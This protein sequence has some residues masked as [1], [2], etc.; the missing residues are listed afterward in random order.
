MVYH[1]P[2]QYGVKSSTGDYLM[3]DSPKNPH[4]RR[5]RDRQP[6]HARNTRAMATTIQPPEIERKDPPPDNG[7]SS[8]GGVSNLGPTAGNLTTLDQFAPEP[9]RTGIWVG[10]AAITM[11]VRRLHQRP[12]RP[13]VDRERLAPAHDSCHRLRQYPRPARQQRNPGGGAPAGSSIRS[14]PR[15]R[16]ESHPWCG[17]ARRSLSACSLLPVSMSHGAICGRGRP[18]PGLQSQQFILLR[19]HG[20]ACYARP[21]WTWLAWGVIEQVSCVDGLFAAPQHDG[22][23]LLLLAFHGDAVAVLAVGDVDQ[24]VADNSAGGM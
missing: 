8:G 11:I 14:R 22:C 12:R 15:V 21:G 19:I 16:T 13:P 3:Q 7:K 17:W 9:S 4:A 1:D 6:R 2:Y 20:R 24:A 10:L 5:F 18:L 23:D